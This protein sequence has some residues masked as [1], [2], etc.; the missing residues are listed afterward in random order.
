MTNFE[1][2]KKYEEYIISM[3]RYFHENPELSGK[4]DGTVK[5]L[6]EELERMGIE[7]DIVENGGILAKVKPLPE[8][9]KGRTV[10]LRADIDALPVQE[11]D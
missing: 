9:D 4:E 8:N 2:A 5:R 11:T 3:R 10:L 1:L 7:Y 6:T